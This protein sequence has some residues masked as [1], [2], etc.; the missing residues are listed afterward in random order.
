MK[1]LSH[2]HMSSYWMIPTACVLVMP[3]LQGEEPGMARSIGVDPCQWNYRIQQYL[4]T[5]RNS[6]YLLCQLNNGVILGQAR[7]YCDNTSV[8][9]TI[10]YKKPK[11]PA[12]LSLLR[13]ILYVVVTKKFFPVVRKIG[14]KENEIADHISRRFDKE[15]A[16]RVFSKFGLH[17]MVLVK[18]RA[19]SYK[20]SAPW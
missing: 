18:P 15:A 20:L 14:T 12:L 11:D 7:L 16:A 2:S 1:T 3:L 10:V 4:Y 17:D 19:E 5:A 8:C 6:G 13:E 9:D